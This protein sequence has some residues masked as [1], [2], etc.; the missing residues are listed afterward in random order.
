[1]R[2]FFIVAAA[3]MFA[4]WIESGYN[5]WSTILARTN[6]KARGTTEEEYTDQRLKKHPGLYGGAIIPILGFIVLVV[7]FLW[8][9]FWK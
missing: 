7:G 1:M 6:F 8:A 5:Y 9:V 2:I 3:V 4:D